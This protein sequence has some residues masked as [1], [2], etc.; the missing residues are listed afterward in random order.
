MIRADMARGETSAPGLAA[1]DF[2]LLAIFFIGIYLEV[3]IQITPSIPLPSAPS[4][5]AGLVLLWRRRDQM[6]AMH[7]AGLFGIILL[8]VG[9][10][11]SAPDY[12]Y[13]PKRFTGLVQLVYSLVIGYAM[14]MTVLLATRRQLARFFLGFS[15]FIVIGCLL[16]TYAG[17]DRLS[18]QVR[19]AIY[20]SGIY[21]ADLRDRLLY[22][23]VRPKL[24]TSE[25]S[26][27]TF[28][29]TLFTLSWFIVSTSRWKLPLFAAL[30][31]S[32]L[33][34]MPGPTLLLS[35]PVLVAYYLFVDAGRGSA[36]RRIAVI[37][38]S[39]ILLVMFVVIGLTVYSERLSF[40]LAGNDPSFFYRV[41]GPALVA[42]HVIEQYPWAGAGLTGAD[43][44]AD[45]VLNVYVQSAN[46][47]AGWKIT[48]IADVL[49][50]F[51]WLHWIYLGLVWG[52]VI[53]VALSAWLRQLGAPSLAFCWIAWAVF[54]QASGA[55]VGPKTWAVLLLSAGLTILVRRQPETPAAPARQ[56]YWRPL[57]GERHVTA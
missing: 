6:Q 24:F 7:L 33:L 32:G 37:M 55:Y 11:L 57:P 2:V 36:T 5:L 39:A 34:A 56:A 12:T 30:L 13:L 48:R 19:L 3:A 15:V 25:P 54:G 9:A 51:F 53:F 18:D 43:F 49:T 20:D 41:I 8:Y 21:D 28:S 38:L 47:S 44:I 31:A 10:V 46:F 52:T 14:L 29:Y 1:F 45:L 17:L 35:L 16:E 23:K 26:A 50:N 4:G 22:G 40:I 42:R 27:V